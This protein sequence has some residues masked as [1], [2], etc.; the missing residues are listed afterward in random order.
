M[1]WR[2]MLLEPPFAKD[3]PVKLNVPA[4]TL[5]LIIAILAV[6][7]AIFLVIALLG[8]FAVL[9]IAAAAGAGYLLFF[10]IPLIVNIVAT[11]MSAWG[12]YQM[13]QERREGKALVIYALVLYVVASLVQA[14]FGFGDFVSWLISALIAF[15]IYYLTVISRF[16]GEQPLTTGATPTPS[17]R[18]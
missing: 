18:M 9:A 16:P 10:L 12:G 3:P 13:F 4:K 11:V 14:V 1:G 2:E 6:I 5:G 8:A 7:G 15:A 17:G